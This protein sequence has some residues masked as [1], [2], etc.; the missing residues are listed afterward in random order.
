[1]GDFGS[2]AGGIIGYAV[3]SFF[4]PF[5]AA[6]GYA[7]GHYLGSALFGSAIGGGGMGVTYPDQKRKS[8]VL[9]DG[10]GQTTLSTQEAVPI[11]F[12][13]TMLH[14]NLVSAYQLGENNRRLA[15]AVALGEGELSLYDLWVDG[16]SFNRLTNF[17]SARGDDANTSWFEFYSTGQAAQIT[18]SN[19]GVKSIG[20]SASQAEEVETYSIH[21]LGS[22]QVR[23]KLRHYAP[24]E[25]STQTWTISGKEEND[26]AFT[27]FFTRSRTFREYVDYTYTVVEPDD[28]GEYH[29][30][31]KRRR[32]PV[33]SVTDTEESVTISTPGKW[34]FK[35]EVSSATNNGHIIFD[36]VVIDS[37]SGAVVNYR[38]HNT[39]YC[40]INLVRT[41]QVGSWPRFNFLVQGFTDSPAY[42][43]KFLLEDPSIGMNIANE[44]DS[45]SFD[46]AAGFCSA[47]GFKI[48]I[49]YLNINYGDCIQLILNCGR[50][51]LIRTGGVYRLIPEEHTPSA[52]TFDTETNIF[53]N[54]LQWGFVDKD[55]K[56]NRL[57]IK[58]AD[59]E[60]NYTIQDLIIEDI[61]MIE[62][63]GF[64][65]E[66]TLDL[67]GTTSMVAAGK[68]G[69]TFFKKSKY[70]NVYVHFEVG[71]Q[72]ALM[73]IGDIIEL[74]A[75]EL[76]Y[77][78]KYFRILKIEET[79]TFG[80]RI[81][82]VEHYSEIYDDDITVNNWHPERLDI[83]GMGDNSLE[84]I[85]IGEITQEIVPTGEG[86]YQ[87]ILTLDFTVPDD[88][89][90]ERVE[91]WVK[92]GNHDYYNYVG[93]SDNGK[94]TYVPPE[95]YIPYQF[96]LVTV[97]TDGNKTDFSQAP[98][99]SYYPTLAPF[100]YPGW[101]G[102]RYGIQ[103][104]G[105]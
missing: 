52:A 17:S 35:L 83:E 85:Y 23:F 7:L 59:E 2:A 18:L 15:V 82:A 39:A 5:G 62:R 44:L 51:M 68:L 11:V 3:G 30:E 54:T 21:I 55:V 34:I 1:M 73:E 95:S 45:D 38:F 58:Y 56:F 10:F 28:C 89:K 66:E 87:N 65:R 57:R 40:L 42:A 47:N 61:E 19:S 26:S 31:E 37:D 41:S 76:G 84:N 13:K 102:G 24:E 98:F 53:P 100:T 94:L 4:G 25:G 70:I 60:E 104:Y 36:A 32:L 96:K 78:N 49:A 72:D 8:T 91:L 90:F 105:Y 6:A 43:L 50:L 101:G 63:D 97:D 103:P 16:I 69:N 93:Q 64:V 14:G 29:T 75:S 20:R 71:L 86:G 46:Q 48:N 22:A 79:D 12:G 80:Y 74:T 99:T 33:E 88:E 9:V 81:Y 77:N 27:T 92:P 67:S